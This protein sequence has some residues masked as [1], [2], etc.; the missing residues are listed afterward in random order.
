MQ[1]LKLDILPIQNELNY[2]LYKL[3]GAINPRTGMDLSELII[4]V[5]I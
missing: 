2:H 3:Y 5:P 1:Y 4:F